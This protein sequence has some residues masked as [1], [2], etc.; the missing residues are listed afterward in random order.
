[1]PGPSSPSPWSCAR[2]GS[3]SAS[4]TAQGPRPPC[5]TTGP[6]PSPAA[7]WSWSPPSATAGVSTAPDG[8]VVWAELPANGRDRAAGPSPPDLRDAPS[9]PQGGAAGV[10]PVRFPGVP[11]DGYLELQAPQRRP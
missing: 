7:A 9:A 11:V 6:T 4:R 1:M 8:K 10:R 2:T 5:A 3:A